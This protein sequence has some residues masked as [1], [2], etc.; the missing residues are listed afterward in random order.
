M[1]LQ[2]SDIQEYVLTLIFLDK[3]ATVD[4][5]LADIKGKHTMKCNINDGYNHDYMVKWGINV[6]LRWNY[7]GDENQILMNGKGY[8]GCIEPIILND[9]E[10]E[11]LEHWINHALEDDDWE[12]F[13]NFVWKFR[14]GGREQYIQKSIPERPKP[15]AEPSDGAAYQPK[16]NEYLLHYPPLLPPDIS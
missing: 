15:K 5:L 14:E 2:L 11:V 6:M 7:L 12:I 3:D 16:P 4:S 1:D 10:Q 8:K 9:R 13:D